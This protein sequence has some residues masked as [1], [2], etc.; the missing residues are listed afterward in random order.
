MNDEQRKRLYAERKRINE[1]K[2]LKEEAKKQKEKEKKTIEQANKRLMQKHLQLLFLKEK[3]TEKK[4]ELNRQF[5][6]YRKNVPIST[7]V[8]GFWDDNG[9]YYTREELMN[10]PQGENGRLSDKFWEL[11]DKMKKN[12]KAKC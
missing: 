4:K 8:E 1:N 2:R 5:K 9:Q 3:E 11:I 12:E 7:W 10:P 6:E